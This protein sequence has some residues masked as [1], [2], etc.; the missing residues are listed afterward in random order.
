VIGAAGTMAGLARMV[1][2]LSELGRVWRR[3]YERPNI[4]HANKEEHEQQ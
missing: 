1:G 4:K 2:L 3:R